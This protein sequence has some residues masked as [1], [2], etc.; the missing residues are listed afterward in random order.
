MLFIQKKLIRDKNG[1][2]LIET[3]VAV[4]ILMIAILGPMSIITKF[5]ID[6]AFAKNQIA[7]AFLAQDGMETVINIIKNNSEIRKD[8][9]GD[10][11]SCPTANWLTGVENCIAGCNVDSSLGSVILCNDDMA[12]CMKL[13]KDGIGFY[14]P[15]STGSKTVFY[16]RI[17]IT[18]VSEPALDLEGVGFGSA[19]RSA[20]VV[21]QVW[22]SERGSSD[23]RGPVVVSNMVIE[24][25]CP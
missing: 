22:W 11:G 5:Y 12:G 21:S 20:Q 14:H 1:F 10:D 16:R 2:T 19:R 18:D 3:F 25:Q 23:I 9:Y 7:S 24:S 4:T 15:D 6:S 8:N 17:K 13:Y